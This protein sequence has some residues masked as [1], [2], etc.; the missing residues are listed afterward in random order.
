M[1]K[2]Q[3]KVRFSDCDA[4]GRIFYSRI[5]EYA[6]IVFEDLIIN[7]SGIKDFFISNEYAVPITKCSAIFHKPIL[8]HTELEVSV[9]VLSLGSHSFSLKYSFELNKI[10]HAE[11]ETVHVFIDKAS[12]NK[13]KI[14]KDFKNFLSQLT[15]K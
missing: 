4:G 11:V 10:L 15:I 14:P 3:I 8:M 6:H 13:I 2:S 5:F 12:N 9:F 1:Y 7:K